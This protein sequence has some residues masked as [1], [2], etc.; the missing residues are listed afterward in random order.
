MQALRTLCGATLGLMLTVVSLV[1]MAP[2]PAPVRQA[3]AIAAAE[4]TQPP[5]RKAEVAIAFDEHG[6]PLLHVLQRSSGSERADQAA[7]K[8]AMALAS[9]RKPHDLAGRRVL[10]TA[11]FE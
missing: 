10:I 5:Q 8:E 6:R 2:T 9:L 4:L 1:L 11:R 3:V 7:V